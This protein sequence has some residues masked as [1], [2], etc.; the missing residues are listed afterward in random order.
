MLRTVTFALGLAAAQT[1]AAQPPAAERPPNVVLLIADDLGAGELS[2][3]RSHPIPTPHL[4]RLI[5]GGAY[6]TAGYVTAPYCAASRAGLITGRYQ[7]RF[8]FEF[9]PVGHRNE[10]PGVGLPASEVTLP[11]M[12]RAGGYATGLVGKWHL[13]GAAEFHPLRHGFDEFFGFLHEGHFYAP[14]PY[15]GLTTMLRRARLPFGSKG[16]VWTS[17]DGSMLLHTRTGRHEPPYDANNPVLRDG[18]PVL[19]AEYLTR[20]FTR[21]AVSFIDRHSERPFFLQLAYSAVHSPLQAPTDRVDEFAAIDDP[22]RQIFAAMYAELDDSVGAVLDALDRRGLTDETLVVFLSDNGGPTV[23]LTSSNAPYRGGKGQ[24]FEGGVRVPFVVR[25]PGRVPAGAV[26][27]TPV[28]STDIF[29][30]ARRLAGVTLD[31]GVERDGRD[32]L[33]VLNGEAG[34]LRTVFWR[35]GE[36]WAL[37][38]GDE[39]VVRHRATDAGRTAWVVDLFDLAADPAESTPAARSAVSAGGVAAD[40]NQ[41]NGPMPSVASLVALTA[42]WER[43]AVDMAE[44]L[45]GR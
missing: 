19:E 21:E 1:A 37:R 2:P 8:G 17:D 24:L 11:E 6:C 32:L 20:A 44:P 36:K 28:V 38:R 14:P 43:L 4:D 35:M 34:P 18:Q 15:A 16:D 22:Q 42:E 3:D 23:E 33:P 40:D 26:V 29:E 41:H 45:W 25:W 39:K 9:N 7:T 27:D 31:D 13:G 10:L 5:A 30:T 12:L